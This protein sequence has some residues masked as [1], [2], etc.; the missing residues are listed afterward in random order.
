MPAK[1][2]A[3]LTGVRLP[4]APRE[5]QE[6]QQAH[7]CDEEYEA[8]RVGNRRAEGV[9][10]RRRAQARRSSPAASSMAEAA[11]A[12]GNSAAGTID[13]SNVCW[14]GASNARATPKTKTAARISSL[15]I[16]PEIVA[17]A[18]DGRDQRF[19]DLADLQHAPA[20]VPVGDLARDQHEH[21]HRQELHQADETE[22]EARCR[23]ARTSA[24]RPRRPSS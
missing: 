24:R 11:T 18:S 8:D 6:G 12:R 5:M 16:Q 13:G 2:A 20:V 17:S 3:R 22:V 14:V 10:E 19:D 21:R 15:L 7:R 4:V 9:E 1:N 23:S